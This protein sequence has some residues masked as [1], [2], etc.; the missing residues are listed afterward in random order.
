MP[1][2]AAFFTIFRQDVV[3]VVL[4]WF[5]FASDDLSVK[6]MNGLMV[7]WPKA[8]L[9][10]V[11]ADKLA[12]LVSDYLIAFTIKESNSGLCVKGKEDNFGD[13]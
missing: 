6:L 11:S 10:P 5:D 1:C 8:G 4:K 3:L 7:L 13:V 9:D 12:F 2:N